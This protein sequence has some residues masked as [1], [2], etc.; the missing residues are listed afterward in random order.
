M[1]LFRPCP[2]ETE[3]VMTMP[4]LFL[5]EIEISCKVHEQENHHHP[6]MLPMALSHFSHPFLRLTHLFPKLGLKK[7]IR[8][9][10]F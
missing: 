5:L 6:A 7:R 8:G 3:A 2:T 1:H 9:V 4:E 10:T